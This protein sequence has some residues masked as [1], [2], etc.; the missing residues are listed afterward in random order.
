M[1]TLTWDDV[2]DRLFE[3]GVRKGVLY[4]ADGH[5]VPWN[6]LISVDNNEADSAEPVYFDGI[7]FNDIV[8]QGDFT[9]TITAFTYP[10]EFLPFE[11]TLEDQDGFFILNQ[12]H[13]RAF[14][15]SYQ[16]L[17][18][19]D[20]NGLESG[21]KIHL[22][23]NLIAI[24]STKGYQTIGDSIEP[25]EF[26]W[27]ITSIPEEIDGYR[28]TA[29]VVIDSRKMDPYLLSDIEAILYGE[30]TGDELTITDH[31]DGTWTASSPIEGVITMLDDTT[32]KIDSTTAVYLSSDTYEITSSA[33]EAYLPSLKA[34]ATFIRSWNRLVI[35]DHGD[36]TWTASSPIEGVIEMINP[37][38]FKI[39][40]DTAEYIESD[41]Y[42][43]TSSD[44]NEGDIWLPR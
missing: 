10:D 3:T 28:P 8:T 20:I 15:L 23:Y 25:I 18:G 17:V 9:A 38:T 29:H 21:Y 35:T 44:K 11:G 26:E 2:G 40:S 39:T 31:G 32:F 33:N 16:T 22:L 13:A 12:P 6:G 30:D 37:T 36:G 42:T 34:F 24:P 43:I 19:D 14:G 41:T 5:G 4:A 7:K 27:S 1:A